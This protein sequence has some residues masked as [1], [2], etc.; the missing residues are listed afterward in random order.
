MITILHDISLPVHS[1]MP[2]YPGDPPI[3]L[4]PQLTLAAD[5]VNVT[6]IR[7]ASTHFGTHVDVPRHVLAGGASL[8]EVPLGRFCGRARV[9]HIHDRQAI[10]AEELAGCAIAPG[11]IVLFHTRN[12]E[13]RLLERPTFVNDY[14]YLTPEGASLLVQRQVRLVG[15]DYLSVD[16]PGE[17]AL[18]AHHILL[19]AG[20]LILEAAALTGVAPGTYQLICL[21]L[22]IRGGDGAPA[23]AILARM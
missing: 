12:S 23:R 3:S 11:D 6:A 18:P 2:V 5:G 19:G 13:E 14:V 16:P 22:R 8:D 7:H 21:P 10:T 15:I 4:E 1:H 9:I 20:V 17:P